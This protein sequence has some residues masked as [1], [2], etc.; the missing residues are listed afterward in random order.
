MNNIIGIDEA[1][2]GA[3]VG[4]VVAGAVI[5]P[6][7]FDTSLLTDSKKLTPHMRDYLYDMVTNNSIWAVGVVNSQTVDKVNVLNA[8]M[9]AMQ[10]AALKI[11]DDNSKFIVDGNKCPELPNCT[12]IVKGDLT[13]PAISAASIIAKV[14]RDRQMLELDTK[15]PEY[16]FASHKGYGTKAHK[17]AISLYGAINE[18]RM[19]F[20]PLKNISTS[21]E[22]P[23]NHD[24]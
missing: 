11:S 12:A 15:Y 7:D 14:T 9:I 4:N 2:R 6:D 13:E 17:E 21:E 8:T 24:I 18:H 20:A 16:G 22:S 10:Q 19:S 1:G 3:L 23:A 5:L